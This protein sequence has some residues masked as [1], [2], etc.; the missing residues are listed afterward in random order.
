MTFRSPAKDTSEAHGN[1]WSDPGVID[2]FWAEFLHTHTLE[3]DNRVVHEL[4]DTM[5]LNSRF[6]AARFSPPFE[7]KR[8][9]GR[10]RERSSSEP[11]QRNLR[12]R[13]AARGTTDSA[14]PALRR[15][16]RIRDIQHKPQPQ[17]PGPRGKG[18]QS[19]RGSA[20]R[21]RSVM[22]K[23]AMGKSAMGRRTR[24][25]GTKSRERT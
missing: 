4:D 5:Y 7:S 10:A 12:Q 23:S 20:T 2:A 19:G 9:R 17:R 25:G 6:L 16:A 15:S 14:Q 1:K 11:P 24:G 21:G 8:K 13:T 3:T 18:T 22:G